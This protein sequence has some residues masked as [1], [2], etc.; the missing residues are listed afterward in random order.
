MIHTRCIRRLVW[1]PPRPRAAIYISPHSSRC[2]CRASPFPMRQNRTWR[3][4]VKSTHLHRAGAVHRD[5]EP[6]KPLRRGGGFLVA[7]AV[8]THHGSRVGLAALQE[9]LARETSS[10]THTHPL[11]KKRRTW[12]WGEDGRGRAVKSRTA[13]FSVPQST[14]CFT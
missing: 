13:V 5:A 9:N 7:A 4:E 6:P 11:A 1:G 3:H 12:R 10:H 8:E 14:A 2:A